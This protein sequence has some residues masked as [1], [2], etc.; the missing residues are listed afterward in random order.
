MDILKKTDLKSWR[1]YSGRRTFTSTLIIQVRILPTLNN[2][3]INCAA[4]KY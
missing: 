1:G 2:F 3:M 4:K